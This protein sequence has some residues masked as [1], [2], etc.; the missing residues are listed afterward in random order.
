[1]C[2]NISYILNA[3]RRE[4][5]HRISVPDLPPVHLEDGASTHLFTSTANYWVLMLSR[6]CMPAFVKL[7]VSEGGVGV[8][9]LERWWRGEK[10]DEAG[11]RQGRWRTVT[12]Q[13]VKSRYRPGRQKPSRR[14]ASNSFTWRGCDVSV[15]A[16]HGAGKELCLSQ[17]RAEHGIWPRALQGCRDRV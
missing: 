13:K 14:E 10:V 2:T 5:I 15:T 11:K 6:P 7:R 17:S 9:E 8:R 4:K 12:L 16:W 3:R 1:M